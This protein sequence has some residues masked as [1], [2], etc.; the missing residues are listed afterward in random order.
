MLAAMVGAIAALAVGA[1]GA[2]ADGGG[3]G[4]QGGGHDHHGH[5]GRN[6]DHGHHF[7]RCGKPSAFDES[8]LTTGLQGDVFEVK[9]GQI[10]QQKSSRADVKQL[11]EKLV[12]DHT[13]S[14]Q[15]GSKLARRLGIEVK[16]EPT[17]PQ[18][19]ELEQ[20]SSLSGSA[21]DA[22]YTH[23]EV[24][25]HEQD[26][27]EAQEEVEKGTNCEIRKDAKEEIPM[28]KEHL[29]LAQAAEKA[30]A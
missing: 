25:D 27:E 17:H 21:F 8:W 13:E 2:A 7:G 30:G 12:A 14:F 18:T 29:A 23:L 26:I 6:H 24:L 9:G 5:G 20:V 19:W 1:V 22:A 10:A 4:H 16:A 3:S 28:L 11:G 15:D